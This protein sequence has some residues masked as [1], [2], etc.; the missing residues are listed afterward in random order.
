MQITEDSVITMNFAVTD[1]EGNM[2]DDMYVKTPLKFAMST[3]ELPEGVKT[4]LMGL[5]QGDWNIIRV[6]PEKGFGPRKKELVIRIHK[7]ELPDDS[8]AIGDQYRRMDETGKSEVFTATGFLGDWVFL[9]RNH[10]W[11]GKILYYNVRILEVETLQGNAKSLGF[12]HEDKPSD[13]SQD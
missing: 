8:F 13:F 11:A 3:R 5:Q 6:E 12:N 1:E 10:P 9:D 7:D 2:L 4:G